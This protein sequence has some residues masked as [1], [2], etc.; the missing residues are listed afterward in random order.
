MKGITLYFGKSWTGKTARLLYDLRGARRVLLVDPKCEQLARLHGWSHIWPNYDSE[1]KVWADDRMSRALAATKG[2]DF[3]LVVHFRNHY[4]E[5]LELL[6]R[7]VRAV[8]DCVLAVDELGLFIPPG[9]AGALPPNITSVAVSGS[10]EGIVF[11]GTAQRPSLVHATV[12]SQASR[13]FFFRVTEK[14]ELETAARY[15]G[16][17]FNLS[18]LPD[19]CCI[20]WAD[21]REPFLDGDLAGKL[22]HVLPGR[23]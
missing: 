2:C 18:S 15:V 10:H 22:G 13:M 23:R 5:Q 9:P 12:R 6:C 14:A 19:H 3:R 11:F 8:K 16:P 7:M 21:G 20:D 1:K 17:S 4:R